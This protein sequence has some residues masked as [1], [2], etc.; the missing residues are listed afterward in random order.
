MYSPHR[1]LSRDF[2]LYSTFFLTL[3]FGH[4]P[5]CFSFFFFKKFGLVYYQSLPTH[6]AFCFAILLMN[7][8]WKIHKIKINQ[9]FYKL[10]FCTP[11][12]SYFDSYIP[13]SCISYKKSTLKIVPHYFTVEFGQTS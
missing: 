10:Q 9:N 5:F 8:R 11:P 1:D 13:K 2:F 6:S 3:V 7:K 12:K 4:L